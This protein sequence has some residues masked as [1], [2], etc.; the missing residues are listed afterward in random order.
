MQKTF[1]DPIHG[2]IAL[3]LPRDRVLLDLIDTPEFQRLRRIHQLGS[4]YLTF[5]GAEH[6]RFTHSLGV[7]H[8]MTR[9][10]DQLIANDP[11]LEN[12][13]KN[14]YQLARI[15]SLLHD[16]GHGPFSHSA[17]NVKAWK[18]PYH[19]ELGARIIF[20]QSTIAKILK[21]HKIDLTELR[22]ILEDRSTLPLVNELLHGH[23]DLDRADYLLRDSHATGVKYGV[24]DLERLLTSLSYYKQGGKLH[25][26]IDYKGLHALEEFILARYFMYEQVYLHKTSLAAEFLLLAIFRRVADLSKVKKL[27]LRHPSLSKLFGGRPLTNYEFWLLDDYL[28][29]T[30]IA[31]WAKEADPILSDLCQRFLSRKLLKSAQ[32]ATPQLA[33]KL[34]TKAVGLAKQ[35]G[36]EPRYYVGMLDASLTPYPP[37][38]FSG[39]KLPEIKLLNGKQVVSI[40]KA[41]SVVAHFARREFNNTKVCFPG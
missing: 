5:H 36:F 27:E 20:G 34:Y 10:L 18:L 3:T 8:L 4:N 6:S 12:K 41:S 24:F 38:D 16:I 9:A 22:K 23:F 2:N 32:A 17:E 7:L 40:S 19:E 28:L 30:A 31:S 15:A 14:Y 11:E 35:K 13:I 25:L 26:A 37:Y 39:K 29:Y 33:K 1:R 21:K